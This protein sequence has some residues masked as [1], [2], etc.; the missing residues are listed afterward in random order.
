MKQETTKTHLLN[1]CPSWRGMANTCIMIMEVGNDDARQTAKAEIRRM[2]AIL[3]GEFKQ[4]AFD[5]DHDRSRVRGGRQHHCDCDGEVEKNQ[6]SNARV[7][8]KC[9]K[10][11]VL[12]RLDEAEEQ[13]CRSRGWS[14]LAPKEKDDVTERIAHIKKEIKNI[15]KKQ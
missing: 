15:L 1:I 13:I 6:I 11:R 7:V 4:G 3:D 2:A 5:S 10:V 14:I 8:E 12:D 9:F